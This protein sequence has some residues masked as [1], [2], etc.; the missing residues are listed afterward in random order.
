M[1]KL[2]VPDKPGVSLWNEGTEQF[3]E[4]PAI[5]G[6]V[7]KLEH[8]LVSLSKWESITTRPFLGREEKT[9]EDTILYIKCMDLSDETPE[10]VFTILTPENYKAISEYIDRK[11]TATTFNED[12]ASKPRN[13]GEFVTSEIIYHWMVALTIPFECETW[14]LNKLLALIKVINLKN[15]PPKKVGRR[16]SINSRRMMNQQ[17][18]AQMGTRG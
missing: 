1:L 12:P 5:A 4:S 3:E 15:A 14:H 2:T 18:K 9:E 17:R 11:M 6:A 7:L 13:T 10:E 16:E 8:S